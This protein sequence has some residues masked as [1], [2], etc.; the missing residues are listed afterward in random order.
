VSAADPGGPPYGVLAEPGA[1]VPP[2]LAVPEPGEIGDRE[3]DPGPCGC[4]AARQGAVYTLHF[5]PPYTPDP[6]AP[7]Y[8]QAAHYTGW[9]KDRGAHLDARLARHEAGQGARL[10]QVQRAA[11][12]TWRLAAVEPGDRARERQ[13]KQHGAARRCPICKAEAQAEPAPEPEPELEAGL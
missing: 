6:A 1:A 9:A 4:D 11:G 3:P 12:G 7:R 10:T 2:W 8:K 13:L 5:D